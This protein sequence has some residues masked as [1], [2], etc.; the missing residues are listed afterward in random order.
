ML[1]ERRLQARALAWEIEVEFL[2]GG[3][4]D[5]DGLDDVLVRRDI[6]DDLRAY[7]DSAY[8]A[9]QYIMVE[10]SGRYLELVR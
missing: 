8:N 4:F 9:R 2:A 5:G 6:R 3:D 7:Y 10:S 1:D